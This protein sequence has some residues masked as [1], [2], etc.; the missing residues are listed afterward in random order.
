[1]I[2]DFI[3]IGTSDFRTIVESCSTSA[4][5]ICVEPIGSYLE[6]LPSKPNVKKVQAAISDFDGEM[7][8]YYIPL[9]VIQKHRLPNWVRGCNSVNKPHPTVFNMLGEKNYY[10]LCTIEKVPVMSFNTFVDTYDIEE[11]KTLQVDTEGHD[12]TILLNYLDLCEKLPNLYA[13]SI[14]FENNV[15]ADKEKVAQV[16]DRVKGLY[17]VQN[18]PDDILLTKI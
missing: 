10:N 12:G 16:L 8:I 17:K 11:I 3:E 2:Y 7:E 14:K 4:V 6:R 1:M 5:G 9:E 18:L 15:L 13:N